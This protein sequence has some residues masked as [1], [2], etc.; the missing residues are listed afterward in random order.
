MWLNWQ[1]SS[2]D[3]TTSTTTTAWIAIV[4]ANA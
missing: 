1:P 4:C 3:L 2:N